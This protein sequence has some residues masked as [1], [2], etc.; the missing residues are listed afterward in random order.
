MAESSG[1]HEGLVQLLVRDVDGE[2]LAGVRHPVRPEA[3]R[4]PTS[5]RIVTA[6]ALV[7][8]SGTRSRQAIRVP[9]IRQRLEGVLPAP[10]P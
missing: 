5:A 8:V 3:L 2:L 6:R 9:R 4:V 7:P 1:Y 10:I